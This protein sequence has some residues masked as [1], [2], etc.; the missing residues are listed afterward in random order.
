MNDQFVHTHV[1]G[2]SV[3][4][5]RGVNAMMVLKMTT[6]VAMATEV[7]PLLQ[8][9]F[10]RNNI[11]WLNGVFCEF[12]N[13]GALRYRFAKT[14]SLPFDEVGLLPLQLSDTLADA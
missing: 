6:S 7:V 14:V 13:Y 4:A 11:K 5:E 8:T 10:P 2:H 9:E 12:R 3:K 1:E